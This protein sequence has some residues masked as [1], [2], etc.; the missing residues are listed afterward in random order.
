MS[1][2]VHAGIHTSP[3]RYTP[4][5]LGRYSPRQVHPGQ[6]LPLH[7]QV[8]S[9]RRY[10]PLPPGRYTPQASKPC[11]QVHPQAGTPPAG[12]PP[13]Y[14]PWSDTSPGQVHFP[15]QVHH[16]YPLAGT[17]LPPTP[18]DG[19][20]SGRYA[21]YWNA[22]LFHLNFKTKCRLVDYLK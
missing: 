6:V 14:T 17:P 13:R 21:S 3:G 16:P 5:P 8:Q 2:S 11:R 19:H 20:C 9:P 12:T 1:A 10:T 7:G 15:R 4:L 18:H 22:F